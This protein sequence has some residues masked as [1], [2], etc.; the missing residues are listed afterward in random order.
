MRHHGVENESIEISSDA[1]IKFNP[2]IPMTPMLAKLGDII[3]Y[4]VIVLFIGAGLIGIGTY[5]MRRKKENK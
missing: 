3:P 1:M 2:P 5:C 4:S